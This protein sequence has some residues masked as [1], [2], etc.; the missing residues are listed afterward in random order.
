MES[1]P[2]LG[3][4]GGSGPDEGEGLG[5]LPGAGIL[6]GAGGDAVRARQPPFLSQAPSV[7]V[8][9]PGTWVPVYKLVSLLREKQS[10]L[11]IGKI[12]RGFEE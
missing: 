12:Q 3:L 8:A 9:A 11:L 10:C 1:C 4:A 5:L 2:E 6:L 7:A